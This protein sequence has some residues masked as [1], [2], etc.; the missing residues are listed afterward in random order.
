MNYSLDTNV[1]IQHLNGKDP[2]VAERLSACTQGDVFIC[3]VV[4]YELLV[5]AHASTHTQTFARRNHFLS[6]F[7][8]YPFD[9]A[10][11]SLCSELRVQLE[12]KGQ[13]IGAYDIQIAAIALLH[14]LT[15]VTHNTR[16]FSRV[17]GLKLVDW[18]SKRAR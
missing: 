10:A 15:L 11:A 6:A 3:S 13:M 7:P 9:D 17:A 2:A 4:R 8:S 5:G 14:N 18:Q 16:E 1:C 12:T